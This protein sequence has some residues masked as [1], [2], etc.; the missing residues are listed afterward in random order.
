VLDCLGRCRRSDNQDP[1]FFNGYDKGAVDLPRRYTHDPS[2]TRRI[3]RSA[4]VACGGWAQAPEETKHLLSE[5]SFEKLRHYGY[6]VLE[7]LLP[8][9]HIAPLEEAWI[10][11][12]K[13]LPEV[14][15]H[16]LGGRQLRKPRLLLSLS[17]GDVRMSLQKRVM[18]SMSLS[19][20]RMCGPG[21]GHTC[22]A[23]ALGHIHWHTAGNSTQ[24]SVKYC[25]LREGWQTHDL[26]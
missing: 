22:L 20:L 9:D 12:V 17:T 4:V 10:Q 14:G 21:I 15:F 1:Q 18:H 6:V 24:G 3:D 11:H 13:N 7:N 8:A 16:P 5:E 23:G 2:G 26:R 19:M 25:Q